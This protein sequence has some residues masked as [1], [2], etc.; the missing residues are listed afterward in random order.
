MMVT[1]LVSLLIAVAPGPSRIFH[2]VDRPDQLTGRQLLL[3][4][5]PVEA[6][7]LSDRSLFKSPSELDAYLTKRDYSTFQLPTDDS[8]VFRVSPG[9]LPLMKMEH[10]LAELKILVEGV[11]P[12]GTFQGK[13]QQLILQHFNKTY[14]VAVDKNAAVSLRFFRTACVS[15]G[16][17]TVPISY[18]PESDSLVEKHRGML[19]NP[20]QSTE[21]MNVP[22]ELGDLS[23]R[24]DSIPELKLTYVGVDGINEERR[25]ELKCASLDLI[26]DAFKKFEEKRRSYTKVLADAASA[27][28]NPELG[29]ANVGGRVNDQ[30][31]ELSNE[32]KIGLRNNGMFANQSE[33]DRFIDTARLQRVDRRF[34]IS[35]LESLTGNNRPGW[36]SIGIDE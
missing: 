18:V 1:T 36:L 30:P 10:C 24:V 32:L 5:T 13:A 12:D 11:T 19:A 31:K 2:L 3:V 4:E 8:I 35:V 33:R 6:A 25:H 14:G 17:R 22:T 21:S 9:V 34:T 23:F 20:V 26:G 27:N 7:R 16:K 15:D 29:R 28:D